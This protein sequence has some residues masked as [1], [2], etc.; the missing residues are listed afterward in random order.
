MLSPFNSTIDSLNHAVVERAKLVKQPGGGF[1]PPPRPQAGAS[2]A[3]FLQRF[4]P[5]TLPSGPMTTAEFISSRPG[6]KK[7]VYRRALA[8]GAGLHFAAEAKRLARTQFFIKVEKTEQPSCNSFTGRKAKVPVPRLINPRD[9][10]FNLELGKFTVQVEHSIYHDI[11]LMFGRPCIAKG[12]NFWERAATIE[13][14][15][16][17]FQDPVWVA[18]DASRFDQHTHTLSL[19][20]EH[21]V[22][23]RYYPGNKWLRFLLRHQFNNTGFGF[24]SDGFLHA[25]LG[26]M[27]MSGDMN[28]ALGN[29]IISAGLVWLRLQELGLR[30][31][32]LVDGDDFGVVMER[33]DS[34]RF[35]QGASEWYLRYGYNINWE[36]PVDVL[37]QVEFCQ[38]HPVWTPDG[39]CMVRN[40][41][42]VLNSDLCGY[43]Q[44]AN[45]RY[46]LALV[47]A[48]GQSGAKVAAGIPILQAFY[49]TAMRLGKQNDA[50]K[51]IEFEK[52]WYAQYTRGLTVT[53]KEVHPK[54]RTSFELAFGCPPHVQEAV[55]ESFQ[56]IT[57]LN[58][59]PGGYNPRIYHEHTVPLPFLY[60]N[61]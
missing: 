44:C 51:L 46:Y 9:P 32:A 45:D 27:R 40:P 39:Y 37:E 25:D 52:Y 59:K 54:T 49:H 8:K 5:T 35:M 50:V 41:H 11:G 2:Y 30:G 33:A 23:K 31:Y 53:H 12:M 28:T 6:R 18:G 48:I 13:G 3:P 15:F 34:E 24:T 26:D 16:N 61:Q 29:C 57:S 4:R 47:H 42:K 21:D 36:T 10:L 14:H 58:L 1:G 43:S 38:T 60:G 19:K 20:F 56:Y 17:E 22:L 55:E 7:G